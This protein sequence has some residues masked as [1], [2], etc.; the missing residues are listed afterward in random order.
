MREI[1]NLLEFFRKRI[2]LDIKH[3][4]SFLW[5]FSGSDL[6]VIDKIKVRFTTVERSIERRP[7]AH[8]C[9]NVLEIPVGEN[10]YDN[11]L[12]LRSE[13]DSILKSGYLDMDIA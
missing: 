6:V 10:G 7:I 1:K 3:N 8:T 2:G 11:F 4:V 13:F 12:L 9:G 5:G